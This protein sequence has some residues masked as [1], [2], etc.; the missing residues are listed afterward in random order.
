MKIYKKFLSFLDLIL[1]EGLIAVLQKVQDIFR[2]NTYKNPVQ[3]ERQKI[4][5][6]IIKISNKKILHGFYKGTILSCKSNWGT[7]D[8]SAKL[9]GIYE[10]QVQEKIIEIKKKYQINSIFNFGAAEGYHLCGLIKNEY[11]DFGYA[12]EPSQEEIFNLKE[13]LKLNNIENKVK[14]FNSVGN[15]QI[16]KDIID[17]EKIK[18]TFFLIDIEGDE[19]SLFNN[20]NI[21]FLKNHFFLI[22]DHS[23]LYHNKN[24]KEK[25][26]KIIKE[27]FTIEI[28]H[29]DSRNPHKFEELNNFNDDEKWL[30]VSE[31][32]PN[33]MSWM[34]LKPL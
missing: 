17:N 33:T 25:Y 6:K 9:L 12:F 16:C 10:N 27:N 3:K 34:L 5:N 26:Y 11:F 20:E 4:L 13:N 22:E 21:K 32:R 28:I 23:T 18:K 19:F 14:I 8:F 30:S 29:S 24:Y 1:N 15:I 2:K 31:S 7:L